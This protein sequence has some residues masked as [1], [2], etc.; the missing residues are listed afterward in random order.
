MNLL[1]WFKRQVQMDDTF[2][3]D[4]EIKLVEAF[5]KLNGVVEQKGK[6]SDTSMFSLLLMFKC[7]QSGY[8]SED[9]VKGINFSKQEF[10]F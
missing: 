3:F 4:K 10:I 9:M 1:K 6:W 5:Q 8:D 7:L 2:L